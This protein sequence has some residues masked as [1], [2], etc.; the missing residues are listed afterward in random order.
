M[1]TYSEHIQDCIRRLEV[2]PKW[3]LH[4]WLFPSEGGNV[5]ELPYFAKTY[6]H[7]RSARSAARRLNKNKYYW[8]ISA[9]NFGPGMTWLPWE[10]SEGRIDYDSK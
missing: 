10:D 8:Q 2:E 4:A 9:E 6:K 3:Q 5:F 1:K 7:L